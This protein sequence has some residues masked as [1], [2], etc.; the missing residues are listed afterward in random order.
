MQPYD[1]AEFRAVRASRQSVDHLGDDGIQGAE[2]FMTSDEH[3][4][5]SDVGVQI[6]VNP[7]MSVNAQKEEWRHIYK[8]QNKR[9]S[10][11]QSLAGPLRRMLLHHHPADPCILAVNL[12]VPV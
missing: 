8:N 4:I 1:S 9:D 5:P 12:T 7:E 6:I 11:R 10:N 3:V 2:Q